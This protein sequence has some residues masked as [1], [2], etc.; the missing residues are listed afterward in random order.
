MT[1]RSAIFVRASSEPLAEEGPEADVEMDKVL[2]EEPAVIRKRPR[3]HPEE[4]RRIEEERRKAEEERLRLLAVKDAEEQT[5]KVRFLAPEREVDPMTLAMENMVLEYLN[6]PE[7]A[8]TQNLPPTVSSRRG[9]PVTSAL[10]KKIGGGLG[11]GS[12]KDLD[13]KVEI[14]EEPE[15]EEG[16]VYDVYIREELKDQDGKKEDEDYGLIIIDGSDDEEW[17]YEGD[18]EVDSDDVYGSDD[19]DSNGSYS[20]PPPQTPLLAGIY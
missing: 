16:F 10:Q 18:E 4:K 17:W 9:I 6:S 14:D 8:G 11:G 1:R 5:R 19:E 7:N 2:P 15:A 3:T 20:P 13:R 12:W